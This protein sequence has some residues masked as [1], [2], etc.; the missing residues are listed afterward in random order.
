L[1]ENWGVSANHVYELDDATLEYQSYA[2]HRDLSSWVMTL[3]ALMRDNRGVSD[4]GMIF[5][6]TLKDFP[7]VSLP[8]DMD[9]NPT[10]RGGRR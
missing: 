2:V 8:L 5:S 7:Q 4:F 3:G 1:N 9:P 6:M 10:G